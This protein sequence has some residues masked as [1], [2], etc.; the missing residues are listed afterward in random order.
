MS[1]IRSVQMVIDPSDNI[2]EAKMLECDPFQIVFKP[3][4]CG[5]PNAIPQEFQ[6]DQSVFKAHEATMKKIEDTYAYLEGRFRP[7]SESSGNVILHTNQNVLNGAAAVQDNTMEDSQ[8]VPAEPSSTSASA[9]PDES[10]GKDQKVKGEA[11]AHSAA[12]VVE[13]I[14]R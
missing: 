1:F 2:A 7:P 9:V 8:K 4:S 12:P 5:E 6:P 3:A 11:S 13:Y 14:F 10:S